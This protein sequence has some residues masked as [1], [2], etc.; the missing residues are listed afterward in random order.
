LS[1]IREPRFSVGLV[2]AEYVLSHTV[3]PSKELQSSIGNLFS[4]YQTIGEV[5]D[6]F[7]DTRENAEAKFKDLFERAQELL[8]EV[9]SSHHTIPTPR[10]CGRQTHRDNIPFESAE[11]YYRRSVFLPFIDEVLSELC[12]RFL[13]SVPEVY[14][15]SELMKGADMNTS[16]FLKAATLYETDTDSFS[17]VKAEA[18]RWK[19]STVSFASLKEAYQHAA[20]HCFPNLKTLYSRSS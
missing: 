1:A 19:N 8:E 9:G 7:A 17:L 11:E 6:I 20:T 2:T 14:H 4:A 16:S 18:Q 10:V 13:D 3:S 5:K 15:M 12:Y